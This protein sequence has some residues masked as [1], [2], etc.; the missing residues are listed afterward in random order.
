[1]RMKIPGTHF[2]L[3]LSWPQGH[4]AAQRIKQIEKCNDIFRNLWLSD[5]WHSASTSNSVT[6]ALFYPWCRVI[7]KQ[8]TIIHLIN[9]YAVEIKVVI[10]I[11]RKSSVFWVNADSWW[12]LAWPALEPC[13]WRLCIPLKNQQTFSVIHSIIYI[14]E[15]RT[16]QGMSCCIIYLCTYTLL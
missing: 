14:Q 13:W 16:L 12:F 10:N 15:S 7:H 9:K 1:M 8:L 3:R 6:C 2:C 4:S 11:G 5:L